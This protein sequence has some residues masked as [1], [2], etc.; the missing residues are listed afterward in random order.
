MTKETKTKKLRDKLKWEY[1]GGF[2]GSMKGFWW[3]RSKDFCVEKVHRVN[4]TVFYDSNSNESMKKNFV[5]NGKLA[6]WIKLVPCDRNDSLLKVKAQ[7]HGVGVDVYSQPIIPYKRRN[8]N[9]PILSGYTVPDDEQYDSMDDVYGAD[10]DCDSDT[11][12]VD[13]MKAMN[14]HI[15][16]RIQEKEIEE[17]KGC[18]LIIHEQRPVLE[19]HRKMEGVCGGYGSPDWFFGDI[20]EKRKVF[21]RDRQCMKKYHA[22]LSVKDWDIN[23]VP[24][25]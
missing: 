12:R 15:G 17:G 13:G 10:D 5:K 9:D 6:R 14:V 7:V 8:P 1:V 19:Y 22:K 2:D 3:N 4:Y 21:R 16:P 20:I 24:R 18:R 23:G 11:D 25:Y